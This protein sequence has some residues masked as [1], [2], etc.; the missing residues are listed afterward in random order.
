MTNRSLRQSPFT[1]A[2]GRHQRLGKQHERRSFRSG[3]AGLDDWFHHFAGQADRRQNSARVWVLCDSEVERGRRPIGYYALVA[4][5]VTVAATPS[6]LSRGLP[7]GYPIGAVLLARLAIDEGRQGEGLGTRLLADA[8]RRIAA[9]DEHVAVPLLLVDAID[10]AAATF[11]ERRGFQRMP[12]D[13]LRLAA[14]LVDI[15]RTLG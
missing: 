10:E 15:R 11:Y 6:E 7:P 2:A 13:H 12:S 5:A 9:A 1:P 14:R 3:R 8:V 4:H